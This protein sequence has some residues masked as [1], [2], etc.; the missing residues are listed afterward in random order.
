MHV[1]THVS[2][3]TGKR[4]DEKNSYIIQ[5]HNLANYQQVASQWFLYLMVINDEFQKFQFIF[6]NSL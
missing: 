2:E 3:S 4:K 1:S 5:I 6:Q